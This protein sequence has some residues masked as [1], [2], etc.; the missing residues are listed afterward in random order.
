ML[1]RVLFALGRGDSDRW[2]VMSIVQRR[3]KA[4][5]HQWCRCAAAALKRV[6]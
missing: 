6:V 2:L 1:L 4:R 3:R 5:K